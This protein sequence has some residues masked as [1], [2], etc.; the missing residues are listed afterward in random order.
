LSFQQ[1]QGDAQGRISQAAS[2]V[3]T[4]EAQRNQ[5]QAQLLQTEAEL[6]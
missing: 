3:A 6:K 4:A 1:A 2:N 5:T